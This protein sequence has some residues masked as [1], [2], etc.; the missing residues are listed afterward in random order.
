MGQNRPGDI[1]EQNEKFVWATLQKAFKTIEKQK[2]IIEFLTNT[3]DNN[4][5]RSR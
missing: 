2:K 5:N 3:N 1:R 4:V